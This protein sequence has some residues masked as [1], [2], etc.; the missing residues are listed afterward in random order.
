MSCDFYRKHNPLQVD[1][2]RARGCEWLVC[3][4]HCRQPCAP[5]LFVC[6]A[7]KQIPDLPRIYRSYHTFCRRRWGPLVETR[8]KADVLHRM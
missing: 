3:G 4:I 7:H 1:S 5:F 2:I 8:R 6:E